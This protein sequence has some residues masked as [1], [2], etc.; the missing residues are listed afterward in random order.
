[1]ADFVYPKDT[2]LRQARTY[3]VIDANG[4]SDRFQEVLWADGLGQFSLDVVG[5][6]EDDSVAF[7]APGT[8]WQSSYITRQRYLVHYRDFRIHNENRVR[9]NY[10]WTEL[11]GTVSMAGRTC[12][13]YLAE[14]I[15]S[16]GSVEFVV[17]QQSNLVM[18]WTRRDSAGAL[19]CQLSTDSLDETPDLSNVLWSQPIAPDQDYNGP[20]D[21]SL[22]GFSPNPVIY[23]PAGFS[24]G[25]QRIVLAQMTYGSQMP[26]LHMEILSDGLVNMMVA[27]QLRTGSPGGVFP[28]VVLAREAEVGGIR[29]MEGDVRSVRTYVVGSLP[30]Q[31]LLAVLGA[32]N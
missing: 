16:L 22:L 28:E 25:E 32:M 11:P 7:S 1:L 8:F 15:Y 31:E 13:R 6:A 29:V 24:H 27:Q 17:D 3:E 10:T 2:L 14:S 20:T 5:V 21:D 12:V 30:S 9:Q 23:Y 26:N 19:V 4:R 18:G